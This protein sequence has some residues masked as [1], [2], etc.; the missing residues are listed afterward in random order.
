MG[1]VVI[2][3]FSKNNDGSW[4]DDYTYVLDSLH[5]GGPDN[6]MSVSNSKLKLILTNNQLIYY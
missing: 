6:N 3:V 2:L 4:P 5:L 1:Q